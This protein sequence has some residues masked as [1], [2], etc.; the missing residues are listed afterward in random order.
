M[1][2]KWNQFHLSWNFSMMPSHTFSSTTNLLIQR[3]KHF[4]ESISAF[5]N[6]INIKTTNNYKKKILIEVYPDN[7]FQTIRH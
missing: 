2:S 6:S 5:L 4:I 7:Q 1:Y 3:E